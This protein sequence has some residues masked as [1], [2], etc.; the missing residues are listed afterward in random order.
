MLDNIG[1]SCNVT[2]IHF[3]QSMVCLCGM[4]VGHGLLNSRG[5]T[6]HGIRLVK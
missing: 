5:E 4:S 6:S 3:V 2:K 1:L